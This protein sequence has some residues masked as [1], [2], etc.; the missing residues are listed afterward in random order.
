MPP[1]KQ[2]PTPPSPPAFPAPLPAAFL[3]LCSMGHAPKQHGSSK[4][5]MT[6]LR[7][8]MRHAQG[9]ECHAPPP[10]AACPSPPARPAP[11]WRSWKGESAPARRHACGLPLWPPA[12]PVQPEQR[13]HEAVERSM[14][15]RHEAVGRLTPMAAAW[16][17]PLRHEAVGRWSALRHEAVWRTAPLRQDAVM[18]RKWAGRHD[19]AMQHG[20]V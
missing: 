9:A 13:R 12:G 3:I 7:E 1:R 16:A 10:P 17:Y 6:L 19:P 8:S 4:D 11:S 5:N 2:H 18:K 15:L 14:T 20:A